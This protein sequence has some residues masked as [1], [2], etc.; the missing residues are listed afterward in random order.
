MRFNKDIL[1][2]NICKMVTAQ[3]LEMEDKVKRFWYVGRDE[4]FKRMNI[5]YIWEDWTHHIVRVYCVTDVTAETT[6][7]L[8]FD[9]RAEKNGNRYMDNSK[10]IV[11]YY[12]L[13][14]TRQM[15]AFNIMRVRNHITYTS[16]Y[17]IQKLGNGREGYI[18]PIERLLK[19][20]I[21]LKIF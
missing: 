9:T 8:V 1:Y 3:Y 7:N 19:S 18:V 21:G 6:G 4:D 14:K 16:Q 11:T 2:D 10:A 12:Y 17:E 5:D 20:K 15:Y 13:P